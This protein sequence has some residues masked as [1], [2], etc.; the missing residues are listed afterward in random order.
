L[1]AAG[2]P[3]K[4]PL[5]YSAE[6]VGK[7]FDQLWLEMDRRYSY[8]FLKNDVNWKVLKENYRPRAVRA[9]SPKELAGVLR[10]MLAHL[11]DM[12]VWIE[13]PHGPTYTHGG[14]YQANYNRHVTFERLADRT[15]C[16]QFAVVGKTKK[17]GFGYFLMVRQSAADD[18]N[19]AQEA[20]RIASLF[21]AKDTAYAKQKFRA[22][23][24]HDDFTKSFERV[25]KACAKPY[26]KP[27]VCLI[28][29]GAVSSGEGFVLMLKA[30]PHV[31]TVG[32]P[33]RGASGNPR[34]VELPGTGISVW[35]SRWVAMQPDG[36]PFEGTGIRPDVEVREPPAAYIGADPTLERGLE[37]LRAKTAGGR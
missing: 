13:T 8:F 3:P 33:T 10:E 35:F 15:V 9:G 37:V 26:T 5:D 12:H 2:S 28:G 17:D 21:C 22:G 1:A 25:L 16:G 19:V 29:P 18:R 34:P 4:R 20:Q 30:L 36:T 27:V 6:N 14:L 31:T 11:R 24:K 32:L 7:A 23:P